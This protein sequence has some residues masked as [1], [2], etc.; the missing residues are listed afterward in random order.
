MQRLEIRIAQHQAIVRIPQ[1]EG[2]GNGLD[3]IA[4]T[5]VGSV[6]ALDQSFCSETSTA[7]PMTCRPA[8]P[9]WR[10]NSQRDPQPQPVAVGVAH[11]EGMI[12]RLN[13]G[14]REL[15]WQVRKDRYRRRAPAR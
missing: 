10:V 14:V 7:M 8:S 15:P 3:G 2:F 1:H 12:D 9:S 4:Q 6:R 11:A 13:F 5:Q